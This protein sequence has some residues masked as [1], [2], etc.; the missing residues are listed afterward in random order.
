MNGELYNASTRTDYQRNN[1]LEWTNDAEFGERYNY[2]AKFIVREILIAIA[3]FALMLLLVRMGK[4][5]RRESSLSISGMKR[6]IGAARTYLASGMDAR[7]R[8]IVNLIFIFAFGML[9][10]GYI[11]RDNTITY[12]LGYWLDSN[13]VFMDYLNPLNTIMNNNYAQ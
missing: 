9:A 7:I 6:E 11:N 3:V 2:F 8:T 1:R 5:A 10:V 4:A 13:D 12:A